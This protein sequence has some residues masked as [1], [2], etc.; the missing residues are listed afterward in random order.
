L[1]Y[2]NVNSPWTD[3]NGKVW[4]VT[5]SVSDAEIAA[6]TSAVNQ[7]PALMSYVS[8]GAMNATVTVVQSSRTITSLSSGCG[9]PYVTP[10][11]VQADID[12]YA[13]AGTYDSII[14]GWSIN[15]VGTATT[16]PPMNYWGC[17]PMGQYSNTHGA[18]YSTVLFPAASWWWNT[19]YPA[20][21][22]LH[23][24]LIPV[25]VWFQDHGFPDVPNVEG[26]SNQYGISSDSNGSWVN[27][28]YKPLMSG[29]LPTAGGLSPG[30]T[31]ARWLSTKPVMK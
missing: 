24:W 21:V 3:D 30:I 23:E 10:D 29:T 2:R 15:N 28:W 18:T 14:V 16:N 12:Q 25:T 6:Y 22:F 8:S 27:T 5:S 20:E 17:S 19:T 7:L 1:L 9:G 11:K 26:G 31:P 13:P 4:Q